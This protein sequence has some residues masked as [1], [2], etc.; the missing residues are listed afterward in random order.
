M[1]LALIVIINF[2]NDFTRP[3]APNL[4]L[5]LI[6][7]GVA[8]IFEIVCLLVG[9]YYQWVNP[10]PADDFFKDWQHLMFSFETA[11]VYSIVIG[12]VLAVMADSQMFNNYHN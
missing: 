4:V 12:V 10:L 7:V 11:F 6:M 8:G 3:K 5:S 2:L 1:V 9:L